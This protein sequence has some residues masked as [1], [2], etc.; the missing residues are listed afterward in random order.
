[1]QLGEW[2]VWVDSVEK[3]PDV[4]GLARHSS[5]CETAFSPSPPVLAAVP[6]ALSAASNR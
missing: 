5:I 3:L 6:V 2:Q 4:L 1:M